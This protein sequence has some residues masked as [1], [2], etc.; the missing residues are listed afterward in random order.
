MDDSRASLSNALQP[1]RAIVKSGRGFISELDATS[2]LSAR[3]R[4][5][6]CPNSNALVSASNG[7]LFELKEPKNSR[8]NLMIRVP[9]IS[10][11]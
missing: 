5:G 4:T 3:K 10:W 8:L 6:K 7:L 9:P 11:N 1:V 2:N